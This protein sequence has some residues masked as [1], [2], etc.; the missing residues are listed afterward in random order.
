MVRQSAQGERFFGGS[1]REAVIR[2][3]L[4]D[5]SCG[6]HLL[7]KFIEQSCLQCCVCH[8]ILCLLPR[9]P[10]P[11][12]ENPRPFQTGRTTSCATPRRATFETWASVA[13]APTS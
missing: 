3:T 5:L 8:L 2:D 4:Q 9:Q 1:P 6:R 12:P 7:V 13:G 11:G 10:Q